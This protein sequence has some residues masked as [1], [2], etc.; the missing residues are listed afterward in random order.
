[1]DPF[2]ILLAL[3][4]GALS[5]W[6]S[7]EQGKD[8]RAQAA[9]DAARVQEQI[10]WTRDDTVREREQSLGSLTA[11][12]AAAGIS[13]ESAENAVSYTAGEYNRALTRLDTQKEWSQDDLEEFQQQSKVNQLFNIGTTLLST[14]AKIGIGL[15]Q[16]K[17]A[18]PETYSYWPT[19]RNVP[20]YDPGKLMYH[21][22]KLTGSVGR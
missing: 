16:N 19:Q 6:G 7:I 1:M 10:D 14:G 2:T 20:V 12:M 13:G 9:K 21:N 15:Y 11:S 3:A 5:I 22:F 4:G 8:E 17:A 18:K